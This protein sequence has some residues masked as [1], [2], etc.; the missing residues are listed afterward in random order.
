VD[1]SKVLKK[2]DDVLGKVNQEIFSENEIHTMLSALDL[3]SRIICG[4]LFEISNVFRFSTA[5]SLD[6]EEIENI[7]KE[8]KLQMFTNMGVYASYGIY[9][10]STPIKPKI[11]YEMIQVLRHELWKNLK[12]RPEY[13]VAAY[14]VRHETGF[15]LIKAVLCV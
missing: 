10:D 5:E 7:M 12:D 6:I 9:C 15:P 8:I 11:C 14:P 3:S 2:I 1:S 13:T 4:Q